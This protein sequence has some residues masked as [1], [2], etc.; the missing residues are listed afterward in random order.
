MDRHRV[1]VWVVARGYDSD[2]QGVYASQ[3]AVRQAFPDRLWK[4]ESEEV[5]LSEGRSRNDFLV[6]HPEEV[7]G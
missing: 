4:R 5:W 7:Q 2:L 3:D 1:I 6:M